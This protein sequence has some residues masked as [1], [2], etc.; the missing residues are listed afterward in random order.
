MSSDLGGTKY[1]KFW[2]LIM[3]NAFIDSQFNFTELLRM[4][5]GK[6]LYWKIEKIHHKTLKV[7]YES[8]D[9]GDNL[10]LQRNTVSVHQ[11]HRRFLIADI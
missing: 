6:T 4:F 8:N 2:V 1:T 5:C 3:C 7:I 11:R 9:T 10:L